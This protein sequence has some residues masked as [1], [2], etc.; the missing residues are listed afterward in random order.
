M[1]TES[2]SSLGN[3]YLPY[4]ALPLAFFLSFNIKLKIL[5]QN[6]GHFK[7]HKS[8]QAVYTHGSIITLFYFIAF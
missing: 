7:I 8:G 1:G 5:G 2:P 4:D 3:D 6:L